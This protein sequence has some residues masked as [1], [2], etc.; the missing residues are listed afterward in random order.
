MT[1]DGPASHEPG[2]ETMKTIQQGIWTVGVR[3][4]TYVTYSIKQSCGWIKIGEFAFSTAEQADRFVADTSA[5]HPQDEAR[6]D[7]RVA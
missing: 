3:D 6:F 1:R 7:R 4:T 2:D 5:R